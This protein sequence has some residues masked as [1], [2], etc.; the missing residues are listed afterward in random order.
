MTLARTP[1]E[2]QL[3]LDLRPDSRLGQRRAEFPM[4]RTVAAWSSW[5]RDG[6]RKRQATYQPECGGCGWLRGAWCEAQN[7]PAALN[8]ALMAPGMACMGLRPEGEGHAE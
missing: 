5:L 3:I 6:G 4:V 1:S 8:P 7:W 2:A